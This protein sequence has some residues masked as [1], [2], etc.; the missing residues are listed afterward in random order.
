MTTQTHA[1]ADNPQ[2][3]IEMEFAE[4]FGDAGKVS[5]TDHGDYETVS[6]T[7]PMSGENCA[8]AIQSQIPEGWEF[9]QVSAHPDTDGM[10][11]TLIHGDY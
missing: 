1:D 9:D 4:A 2:N 6:V 11:L 3:M 10:M 5:H 8:M 7:F